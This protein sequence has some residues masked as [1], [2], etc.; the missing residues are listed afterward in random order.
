MA[1]LVV[2]A[3]E[4]KKAEDIIVLNVSEITTI[5]DLFVICSGRSERQGQAIPDGIR[6]KATDAGTSPLGVEGYSAGRWI[7]ID[8]R[9]VVVHAFVPSERQL[10]RL[11]RL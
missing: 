8:L 1:D 3:A 10:A 6:E 7:P 2:E 11:G 9:A 5:A 4:D